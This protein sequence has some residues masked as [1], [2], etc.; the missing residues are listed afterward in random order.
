MLDREGAAGP[1]DIAIVGSAAEVA[2]RI[3]ALADIGVTDF[4]AVE[5]RGNP[6]EAAATRAALGGDAAAADAAG[7]P[8]RVGVVGLIGDAAVVRGAGPGVRTDEA[9]PSASTD[10]GRRRRRAEPPTRCRRCRGRQCRRARRRAVDATWECAIGRRAARPRRPG[11]RA[12]S[13]VALTRPRARP[14]ATTAGRSCSNPGGPGGSG[15]RAGVGARRPAAGRAAR[16]AT[17]RS[18]WDPRG[19]G[20]SMPADRLRP[21]RPDRR[22]RRRGLRRRAPATSLGPGRR[23]RRGA[24]P[25]ARSASRSATSGS[26]TS[27]TATARRSGRCTRWPTRT[28]SGTSCSTVRSTRRPVTRR[29]PASRR[30][31]ARLRRRRAST[32]SIDRFIELC[33]ASDACARRARTARPLVDEL[34]R[35]DPRR[36][37]PTDFAGEPDAARPHRPRRA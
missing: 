13:T 16:R 18:G 12:R 30:R 37:R 1:A 35:H 22:A 14:P 36:C 25:R 4:A 8:R 9:A 19:V 23:R 3:A 15:H 24:R 10:D 34:E 17:T 33:D 26:T 31:R 7:A 2:D 21:D 29:R 32:T 27:A 11:G 6:D 5:F 20:R 28:A